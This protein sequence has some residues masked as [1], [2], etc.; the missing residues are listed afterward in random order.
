MPKE[1]YGLD[2]SG[3]NG[4]INWERLDTSGLSF[5]ILR[6][7]D[8]YGIDKEFY[9]NYDGAKGCGLKI[10]GYK[11]SY[12]KTAED[13][14]E[15]AKGVVSTLS[16]RKLDFPI[17]YDLESDEQATFSS[18]KIGTF[19]EAF[20]KVIDNSGYKFGIY[21]NK[22][23]YNN[24]IPDFA[25]EKY[26]F[27]VA[28]VPY[29]DRDDGSVQERLRPNFGVGWQYSW[30]KKLDGHN[31]SFD[32][33]IFY[34][35]YTEEVTD[36]KE[37]EKVGT[38]AKEILD[39]ARSYIGYRESNG[40]HKT[41]ID[42]YNSYKPLAR[43]YAVQ[44]TDQWCDTFV[45]AVFIKAGAVSLLG[46]T[47]CGVEEHVKKFKAAGIWIEDGTITPQPGDIIVFNWGQ[48]TQPNDGY[49][50]HIGFVEAVSGGTITTIEGNYKDSVGR[51][52]LA[53]GH[54]NIR[55]FARP[56]YAEATYVSPAPATSTSAATPVV[57]PIT[58]STVRLNSYNNEVKVLQQ[59]LNQ[60][61]YSL[62]VDG[63]FGLRTYSAVRSYQS[64][65]G[66]SVDG[67][68]GPLTWA[69]LEKNISSVN[70]GTKSITEV[71]KDVIAGKYGN[72]PNRKANLEAA[73]YNY[74][75]VQKE[76]NRLLK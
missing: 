70:A 49:S 11:Y 58:H 68:V 14:E 35:D 72:M 25:K 29:K 74:D 13:A 27:W 2:I 31:D 16:G 6:I 44:Y 17:F 3:E 65:N 9:R 61:G 54:G 12:A 48:S 28:A 24:I 38:T 75:A 30:N 57:A 62:E 41:I 73:G 40:S 5:V 36:K 10:G 4:T 56:K 66:L 51:R 47:E 32:A 42:I 46:G 21:S 1:F 20:H 19:I 34:K 76:V 22:N 63:K 67:I 26:E 52:R 15:E 37:V 60:V 53:V 18:Y 71:A 64:K 45:S 43:G 59:Y 55:G 8:K 33:D 7:T 69:S 50:D 39:I 23:W